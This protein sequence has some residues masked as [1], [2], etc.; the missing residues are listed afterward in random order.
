MIDDNGEEDK[1]LK[2]VWSGANTGWDDR[3]HQQTGDIM[4]SLGGMEK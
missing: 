4:Q 2:M 3:C 1:E